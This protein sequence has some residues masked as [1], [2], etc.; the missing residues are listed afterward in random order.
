MEVVRSGGL[1]AKL[2]AVTADVAAAAV[3]DTSPG[4]VK[5]SGQQPLVGER[6]RGGYHTV[7]VE[8]VHRA[9]GGAVVLG[10]SEVVQVGDREA[11]LTL[12]VCV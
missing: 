7:V 10:A 6:G 1:D 12:G 11:S 5:L 8:H 2:V 9:L 3:E 4:D